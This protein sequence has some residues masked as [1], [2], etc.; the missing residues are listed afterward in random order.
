MEKQKNL[1]KEKFNIDEEY[2]NGE[3]QYEE[4]LN[5]GEKRCAVTEIRCHFPNSF[6][7]RR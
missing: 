2:N 3:K 6:W 4:F 1:T 7:G 5:V